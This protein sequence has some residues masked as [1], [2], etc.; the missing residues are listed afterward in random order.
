MLHPAG[1]SSWAWQKVTAPPIAGPDGTIYVGTVD[2]G[3]IHAI[4][5]DG[6][7]LWR[8]EIGPVEV[9]PT[10]GSVYV[11]TFDGFLFAFDEDGSYRWDQ[12]ILSS[13]LAPPVVSP[14]GGIY[15]L[16]VDG[17]FLFNDFGALKWSAQVGP[18]AQ[19]GLVL[20]HDGTAYVLSQDGTVW[21]VGRDGNAN[22]F[23][24]DPGATWVVALPPALHQGA[25]YIGG[26]GGLTAL[27]PVEEAIAFP[28]ATPAPFPTATAAPAPA[29]TP[30]PFRPATATPAPAP[31][32]TPVSPEPEYGG[33]LR[34]TMRTDPFARS[35]YPYEN[36]SSD[37]ASV[38]SLIFSRLFRHDP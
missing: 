16:S 17:L 18:P 7:E 9:S 24:H 8:E 4:S 25:L 27:K 29:A 5:P 36:I 11:A 22:E 23:F 14:D 38:N 26:T 20:D 10:L 37:K 21:A 32:S 31:T 15:V 30:T 34:L 1:Q 35:L 3:A 19:D 6:E 13:P 33:V 12:D 28:T 2:P